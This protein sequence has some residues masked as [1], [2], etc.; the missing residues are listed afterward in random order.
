MGANRVAAEQAEWVHAPSRPSHDLTPA[1]T[2]RMRDERVGTS[3][4]QCVMEE[5]REDLPKSWET[6]CGA[7]SIARLPGRK[8]L[9][10]PRQKTC[11]PS[12]DGSDSRKPDYGRL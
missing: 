5:Y 7:I 9:S 2:E 1:I 8:A 4:E 3:W 6:V 11:Y 10:S 12:F